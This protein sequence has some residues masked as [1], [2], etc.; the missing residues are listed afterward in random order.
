MSSAWKRHSLIWVEDPKSDGP[1]DDDEGDDLID[2]DDDVPEDNLKANQVCL[3][4][5]KSEMNTSFE[6]RP[7]S[8][9]K[10]CGFDPIRNSPRE[11]IAFN[12]Q[13]YDLAPWESIM[14]DIHD[15]WCDWCYSFI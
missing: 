7:V 5:W 4:P 13:L 6:A 8:I 11:S 1:D 14:T 9:E 3:T 10:R 15:H 12:P 2:E